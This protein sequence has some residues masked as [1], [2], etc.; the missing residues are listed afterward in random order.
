L[1][2]DVFSFGVVLWELL[3]C[4][5]PYSDMTPL[6]A[7]VGVVQKGLRPAIP[8]NCLPQLAGVMNACW[9]AS[10]MHRCALVGLLAHVVMDAN[11]W[12]NGLRSCLRDGFLLCFGID[13]AGLTRTM[14]RL[15]VCL[16]GRGAEGAAASR[17]AQLPAAAR[18]CHERMLGRVAHAQV[19]TIPLAF[20]VAGARCR[21]TA[22]EAVVLAV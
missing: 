20:R 6:Q 2:A 18:W 7:A 10:P 13:A 5:I 9:D 8:A 11:L 12:Q 15:M 4:K 21:R 1:Q 19:C 16:S 3:T 14:V 17:T 22:L